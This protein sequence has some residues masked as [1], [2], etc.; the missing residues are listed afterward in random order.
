MQEEKEIA[1]NTEILKNL[2]SA[3]IMKGDHVS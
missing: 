2:S 3:R 1:I